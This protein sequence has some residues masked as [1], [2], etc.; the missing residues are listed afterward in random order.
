MSR[1]EWKRD[2]V[3][4]IPI[5]R[6]RASDHADF[7]DAFKS[8]RYPDCDIF[9]LPEIA[10][11]AGF[12][13]VYDFRS[14][15]LTDPASHFHLYPLIGGDG[16]ILSYATNTTSAQAGGENYRQAASSRML[17][18]RKPTDVSNGSACG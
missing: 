6:L 16:E 4:G 15:A 13:R 2:P 10:L 5:G 8:E 17:S 11:T 3:T 18:G 7:Y 1:K 9:S 14:R 12:T